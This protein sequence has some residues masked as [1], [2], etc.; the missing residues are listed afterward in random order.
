MLL[1]LLRATHCI[2]HPNFS[3]HSSL[4][5]LLR[6]QHT[7]YRGRTSRPGWLRQLRSLYINSSLLLLLID[8]HIHFVLS[9]QS[10]LFMRRTRFVLHLLSSTEGQVG[11]PQRI[12]HVRLPPRQTT[13]LAHDG[14]DA[15]HVSQRSTTV[16]V[17]RPYFIGSNCCRMCRQALATDCLPI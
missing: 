5:P 12:R 15:E 2:F 8:R 13:Q 14:L 4:Y 6:Q 10:I 11:D 3:L 17:L 1:H 9:L 7:Y 16:N